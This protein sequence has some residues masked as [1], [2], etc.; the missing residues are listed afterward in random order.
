MRGKMKNCPL[1][2]GKS[3][4]TQRR[5]KQ[6]RK[7]RPLESSEVMKAGPLARP[8]VAGM[9]FLVRCGKVLVVAPNGIVKMN[10]AE[11]EACLKHTSPLG[12]EA[13]AK[14]QTKANRI[15]G[16]GIV[17]APGAKPAPGAPGPALL[18]FLQCSFVG[19]GLACK[20]GP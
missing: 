7:G 13:A 8:T 5:E 2:P 16:R 6:N 19:K 20:H 10:A 12:N 9:D 4:G 17:K 1:L 15:P 18:P 3:P 14:A 11:F